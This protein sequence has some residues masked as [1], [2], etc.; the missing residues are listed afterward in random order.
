M[1]SK[2]TD[3]TACISKL[4]CKFV[5][6]TCNKKHFLFSKTVIN[7]DIN[8]TNL[9]RLIYILLFVEAWE[10]ILLMKIMRP[11]N[12]KMVPSNL[13]FPL[14]SKQTFFSSYAGLVFRFQKAL[15]F[16]VND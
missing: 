14:F 11:F 2:S 5:V 10:D 16:L 13:C 1:E 12:L 6:T 8:A 4:V 15:A 9:Q 3:Q 7:E